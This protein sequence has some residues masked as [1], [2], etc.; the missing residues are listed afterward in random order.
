[1]TPTC[2]TSVLVPALLE[3]HPAHEESRASL[4]AVG[5]VPAHVLLECFSVLT[6]LPAPHRLSAAD[7]GALA[8]ALPW[9]VLML[10]PAAHRTLLSSLGP[11]KVRGG[12]VYDA[13]IAATARAHELELLTRDTRARPTYDAMGV[14]FRML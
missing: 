8:S 3:W 11:A 14:A 5:A 10:T 7:A 9:D 12:A 1:M 2:D 4:A 13:L 6:R